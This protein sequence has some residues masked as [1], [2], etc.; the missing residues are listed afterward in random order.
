MS[1]GA[2]SREVLLT[3][4]I[5]LLSL[6]GLALFILGIVYR[7]IT[8]H[9]LIPV[10]PVYREVIWDLLRMPYQ[11]VNI[12]YLDSFKSSGYLFGS[13]SD[14]IHGLCSVWMVRNSRIPIPEPDIKLSAQLLR[15]IN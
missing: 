9:R 8:N 3:V 11:L 1:S 6:S 7:G 5:T 10:S 12:R 2:E 15:H 14:K 4:V 13:S